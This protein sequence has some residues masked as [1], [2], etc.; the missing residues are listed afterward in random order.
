VFT[1]SSR[2]LRTRARILDAA[3]NIMRQHGLAA[4]TTR[5]IAR[6]AELTEAAL[7]K[8]FPSKADLFLAVLTERLSGLPETVK[9]LCTHVGRS[10]VTATLTN[11][12]T[13]ALIFYADVLPIAAS[14][15]SEPKL[16]ARNRALLQQRQLG[17]HLA[18]RALAAYLRDEQALGRVPASI[19]PDTAAAMVLGA[20]F[21]HAFLR[22]FVGDALVPPLDEFARALARSISEPEQAPL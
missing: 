13:S 7:Y 19:D 14:F 20:C 4:A 2:A 10:D 5:E 17:P 15:F 22:G 8:Y 12:A 9:E 3:A 21:Q 6:A 18:N 16:L 1:N 11:L